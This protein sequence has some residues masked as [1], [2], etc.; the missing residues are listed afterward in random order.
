MNKQKLKEFFDKKVDQY[1]QPSFIPNDPVCIPHMFKKKQDI[2]IAGFFAAS[3]AWGNR[4]IIINKSREL[5][6]RM[7]NAPYE[8]ITG[9]MENDLMHLLGFKHRTFNDTDLLYFIEFF[10]YHYSTNRSLQTAFT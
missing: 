3:V 6:Q 4:T 5:M 9:H 10:K 7:D 1:D 2:E 8:F